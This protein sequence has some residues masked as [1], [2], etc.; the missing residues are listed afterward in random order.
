SD[1]YDLEVISWG[2]GSGVPTSGTNLV[3]VGTDNDDTLHFRIFDAAGNT[4]VDTDETQLP[5]KAAAIAAL[6]QQLSG[7]GPPHVLAEAE[8]EAVLIAVTALVGQNLSN[9]VFIEDASIAG[10]VVLTADDIDATAQF[11]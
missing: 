5:D 10:N 7:L 6:K 9:K 1:G 8:K 4:V 11:G 2:D 3:V